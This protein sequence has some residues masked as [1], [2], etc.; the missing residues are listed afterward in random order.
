MSNP[1]VVGHVVSCNGLALIHELVSSMNVVT[2]I[3]TP[4]FVV[5]N[6][7]VVTPMPCPHNE[8]ATL[9]RLCDG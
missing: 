5:S 9:R 4:T 8:I 1:I 6:I 7:M 3:R 2:N